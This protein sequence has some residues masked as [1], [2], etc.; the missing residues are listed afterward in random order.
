MA[1]MGIRTSSIGDGFRI[2]SGQSKLESRERSP[3]G[4]SSSQEILFGPS[5]TGSDAEAKNGEFLGRVEGH[6]DLAHDRESNDVCLDGILKTKSSI[7]AK[8]PLVVLSKDDADSHN[9]LDEDCLTSNFEDD[10]G[11][12]IDQFEEEFRCQEIQGDDWREVDSVLNS[13]PKIFLKNKDGEVGSGLLNLEHISINPLGNNISQETPLL[14]L[15]PSHNN[16]S[17]SSQICLSDFLNLGIA[18]NC[19]IETIMRNDNPRDGILPLPNINKSFCATKENNDL[20]ECFVLT[21]HL[22]GEGVSQNNQVVL[23][24]FHFHL[25]DNFGKKVRLQLSTETFEKKNKKVQKELK[26]LYS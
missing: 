5:S 19:F 3:R 15:P 18:D 22:R 21:S 8:K 13:F 16:L 2:S 11:L 14:T 17:A 20:K 24:S 1:P 10:E 7:K 6:S 23:D 26:R 12:F 4:P 25:I 9:S